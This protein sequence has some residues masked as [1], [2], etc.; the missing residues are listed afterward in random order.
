MA[1][2]KGYCGWCVQKAQGCLCRR[3]VV[4]EKV[5]GQVCSLVHK[6]KTRPQWLGALCPTYSF[7][8]WA[9]QESFM[10][11]FTVTRTSWTELLCLIISSE[12][13]AGQ[14]RINYFVSTAC[15][16]IIHCWLRRM[17][18]QCK[19]TT[20]LLLTPPSPPSPPV[21]R[22]LWRLPV[23]PPKNNSTPSLKDIRQQN[24]RQ[25]ETTHLQLYFCLWQTLMTL[26][27]VTSHQDF[28]QTPS[29]GTKNS[30]QL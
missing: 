8:F 2:V 4:L 10:G 26:T 7:V 11:S 21:L 5:L 24:Q 1:F 30:I 23:T 25:P 14:C 28:D 3:L 27:R 6:Y 15:G 12:C 19:S 22:P 18:Y 13:K 29:G 17:V 20:L 9:I 16:H